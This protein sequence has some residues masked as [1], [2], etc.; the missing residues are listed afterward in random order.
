MRG[1]GGLTP[2]AQGS[3]WRDRWNRFRISGAGTVTWLE[4]KVFLS[5]DFL[6]DKLTRGW[7][8][9]THHIIAVSIDNLESRDRLRIRIR[10]RRF[11]RVTRVP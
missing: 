8:S 10:V 2:A 4:D 5:A 11:H 1:L 3:V 6:V 7:H 9:D